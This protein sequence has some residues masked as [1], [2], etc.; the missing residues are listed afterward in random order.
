[1][2]EAA[3]FSHQ[4]SRG[5][6]SS[7]TTAKAAPRFDS[8]HRS[9][10]ERAAALR[11]YLSTMFQGSSKAT[12]TAAAAAAVAAG[13]VVGKALSQEDAMLRLR[14]RLAQFFRGR[15]TLSDVRVPESLLPRE[16]RGA[17]DAE[18]R[19]RFTDVD[20]PGHYAVYWA[21][22]G[23]RSEGILRMLFAARVSPA[24][25][26]VAR[27]DRGAND[28]RPFTVRVVEGV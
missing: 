15:Y 1:M 4:V 10:A 12:A 16:L 24:E 18:G 13:V 19:V 25:S 21:G 8:R 7:S 27:L 22:G 3:H 2:L 20:L 14:L 17:A 9:C 23:S 28:L 6:G 5:G 26:S 11:R